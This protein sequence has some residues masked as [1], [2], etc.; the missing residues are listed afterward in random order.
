[1][2]NG[3]ADLTNGETT[4]NE[5]S[6]NPNIIK[7]T[8]QS[9]RCAEASKALLEPVPITAEVSVPFE[10]HRFIIGQKGIGVRDM[11]NRYD[12][13]IRVPA[14][15]AKSDIILISGIS[16]NVES[17]KEEIA[18]EVAEL[19]RDKAQKYTEV[20]GYEL[21]NNTNTDIKDAT[22]SELDVQ[23]IFADHAYAKVKD[24]MKNMKMVDCPDSDTDSFAEVK[25]DAKY[26]KHN[27]GKGGS[28]I[29]KLKSDYDVT[30]NIPDSD[31][32]VTLIRIEGNKAGV[33]KAKKELMEMTEKMENEKEKDLEMQES[34]SQ[35]KVPIFTQFHK[36]IIGKGGAN[37]R[38]IRDETDTKVDLPDSDMITTTGKKDNVNK[39]VDE[40]QSERANIV[41]KEVK[42]PAKIQ[43]IMNE[44][45]EVRLL[46][47]INTS[48]I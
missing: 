40:I 28:T 46:I 20:T 4:N 24:S 29:N 41:S 30:I 37:I 10:F 27:H 45:G 44:C 26:H 8:G 3:N 18:E 7:I 13:N 5:N 15:D 32:G 9:E 14:Q 33:E 16:T 38:R 22:K 43:S 21:N 19:K 12:V 11:M 48:S 17:A 42:I 34:S 35:V 2:E 31:S 23:V 25:I 1:M 36:S 47:I 6:T 39:A